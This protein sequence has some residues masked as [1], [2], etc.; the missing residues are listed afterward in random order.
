MPITVDGVQ[1]VNCVKKITDNGYCVTSDRNGSC[2]ECVARMYLDQSG[3]CSSIDLN[4]QEYNS[5]TGV[6]KLCYQGYKISYDAKSNKTSCAIFNDQDPNCQTRINSTLCV[7]CY[8]G[9]YFS[10]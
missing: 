6:C 2:I 10:M 4:C 1:V 8:Q 5:K 7:R 3:T 9:F